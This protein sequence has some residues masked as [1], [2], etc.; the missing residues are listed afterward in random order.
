MVITRAIGAIIND[1]IEA[2][3]RAH[4]SSHD[5]CEGIAALLPAGGPPL[6]RS[7]HVVSTAREKNLQPTASDICCFLFCRES[8][9]HG[10]H[11]F[12]KLLIRADHV[13][14]FFDVASSSLKFE[15]CS[16]VISSPVLVLL[17]KIFDFL[18]LF[19]QKKYIHAQKP[20]N[21]L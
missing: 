14:F 6:G 12:C 4:A 15:N 21:A 13:L 7:R 19:S 10:M 11:V 17:R 2:N 3:R 8:K 18:R 16:R 1:L 5:E 9:A 20:K